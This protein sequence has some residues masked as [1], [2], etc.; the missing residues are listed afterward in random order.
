MSSKTRWSLQYVED[1]GAELITL[2]GP[3]CQR[4]QIAG[5]VRRQ[6]PDPGDLEILAISKNSPAHGQMAFDR[7]SRVVPAL[8]ASVG[9]LITTGVLD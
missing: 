6:R 5:S 1:V 4:I 3:A 8:D 9:E 2:L 7:P